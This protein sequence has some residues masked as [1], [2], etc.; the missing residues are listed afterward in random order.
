MA[1][2]ER[3]ALALIFDRLEDAFSCGTAQWTLF[4]VFHSFR[5][6]LDIENEFDYISEIA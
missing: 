3:D 4:D 5:F 1:N 6:T 2:V